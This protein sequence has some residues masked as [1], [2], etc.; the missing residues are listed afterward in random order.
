MSN[1]YPINSNSIY[2]VVKWLHVLAADLDGELILM[3]IEQR[4]NQQKSV[5]RTY[6]F[7]VGAV[8]EMADTAL[9]EVKKEWTNLYFGSYVIPSG[10][11]QPSRGGGDD[12]VAVLMLGVDQDADTGKEGTLPLEPNFVVQTSHT[13]ALNRQSYYVFEPTRRPS[14]EEAGKLGKELRRVTGADSG[15]GDVARVFRVPGTL[16]W[17]TPNKIKRGRPLQ[18]QLAIVEQ[19]PNGYTT[20]EMLRAALSSTEEKHQSGSEEHREHG[21]DIKALL[22]RLHR[23]QEGTKAPRQGR[24]SLKCCLCRNH[25]GHPREVQ[26]RGNCDAGKSPWNGRRGALSA[27]CEGFVGRNPTLSEE[28]AQLLKRA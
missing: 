15:T 19:E 5:P 16:N 24:G 4:P 22:K 27:R 25:A 11:P 14:V 26:R 2:N 21:R 28:V 17:P 7:S 9:R 23:T 10:L 12:I 13:P 1:G 3:A 18:P 8:N 6:R 20:P